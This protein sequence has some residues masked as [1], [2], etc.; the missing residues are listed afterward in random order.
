MNKS[1]FNGNNFFI[2]KNN[3]IQFWGTDI[4][5]PFEI[6]INKRIEDFI[7]N[8]SFPFNE[9]C[10]FIEDVDYKLY[11]LCLSYR[12]DFSTTDQ[13]I[14]LMNKLINIGVNKKLAR[15]IALDA[16]SS[17]V[18]VN[19][20]YLSYHDLSEK[21]KEKVISELFEFYFGYP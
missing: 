16:G 15:I 4:K 13:R 6:V 11:E 1:L 10:E 12:S 21:I 7:L 3:V 20:E 5:E 14:V 19:R 18:V 8:N 9:I 17:Q 2:I